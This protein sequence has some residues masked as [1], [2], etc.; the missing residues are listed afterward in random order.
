MTRRVI[1]IGGSDQGRQAI[2][3]IEQ[4]GDAE[5][6]GVLDRSKHAPDEVA[7]YPVLGSDEVLAATAAST[8]AT[9][10]VAAIGD[11]FARHRVLTREMARCSD[12]EPLRVIH[13]AAIVARDAVVGPGSIIMAGVVVSN[14]C[15]V[16]TGTL[17]AT[18]SSL[19]H[20]SVLGDCSSFAPGVTTGGAVHIGDRTAI[21]LGANVTHRV[22]V[23]RDTVVG[24]GAL[25]LSDV[26]DG[27]VAYGAPARVARSRAVDEPYLDVPPAR[28]S[29]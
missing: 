25:V 10:F 18:R 6:M 23:G 14:G 2:D 13:P 22:T 16:G 20:D 8:H 4:L 15:R 28:E 24:A 29:S 21:G 3:I 7:G 11:N 12:L 26:P 1:V 27:V 19:D 17:L 5:V 9:A